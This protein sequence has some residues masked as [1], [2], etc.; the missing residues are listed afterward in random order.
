MQTKE[1]DFVDTLFVASAHQDLLIITE[2]GVL[3]WLKVHQIPAAGRASRGKPLVNMLE[4]QPGDRIHAVVPVRE[5]APDH[6]LAMVTNLGQIK[7]T[8]LTEFSRRRRAGIRAITLLENER[9]VTVRETDGRGDLVLAASNGMAIRFHESDA[10]PMGRTARGVRGIALDRGQEVV[11]MVVVNDDAAEILA[12]TE[13]GYGK[14]T[15]SDDYRNQRRGGRG[16]ITIKCTARNGKLLT[17][18]GVKPD[19]E[20]MVVTRGGIMIRVAVSEVSLLG[21]NTQG[22]RIINLNAGDR[23]AGVATI[24][25]EDAALEAPLGDQEE[26]PATDE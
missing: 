3:H 25:V 23:V 9:L 21:R 20:L 5:Y 1:E 14:R 15:P 13:H 4:I 26:A 17:L 12:V 22:V 7:R 11:G 18:R 6:Y 2:K 10:R 24:T 8:P 19:E 16:L